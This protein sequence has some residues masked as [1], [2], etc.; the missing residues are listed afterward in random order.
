M[1]YKTKP[2]WSVHIKWRGEHVLPDGTI[3]YHFYVNNS[4]ERSNSTRAVVFVRDRAMPDDEAQAVGKI[5]GI[6]FVY[7]TEFLSNTQV[8]AYQDKHGGAVRIA[9]PLT[10]Q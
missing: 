4:I 8:A 9:M 6:S 7:I 2:R 1:A 10:A 3:Q 5:D